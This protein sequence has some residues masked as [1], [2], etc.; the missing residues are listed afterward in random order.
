MSVSQ[1]LFAAFYDLLNVG[2]EGRLASYREATAGQARGD[3]LEIGGGT[4]ANLSFYPN[5]V[6]L[7]VVEPN[8]HMASRFERSAARLGRQVTMVPGAGE[9]LPFAD[10][11]FDSVV[12]TLV[13][14]TV[15]DLH[16]VV[17]EA[18]RVLK[19]GGTL[20]FYEHVA[21]EGRLRRWWEDRLNP[22]WRF[23]TTG[24]NL[25]RDTEGAIRSVGFSSVELRAFELSVGL[26]ITLPN[27]V[28]VAR[29]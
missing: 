3:V 19:P 18:K 24:C 26:L 14:C 10:D 20:Y 16:R 9:N 23:C 28:G 4:G 17:S 5:D 11:S 21:S 2:V 25:N 1:Y 29:V 22:T 13:L 6:R 7:T 27:I 12:T 8:P 15:D